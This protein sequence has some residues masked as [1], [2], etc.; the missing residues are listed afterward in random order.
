M[1]LLIDTS[2]RYASIGLSVEGVTISEHT[3]RSNRNHSVELVPSIQTLMNQV[4]VALGELKAIFIAKGPGAFS[5]LRVGISTA[6]TLAYSLKIPIVAINTLEIES[7]PYLNLGYRVNAIIKAGRTQVYIGRFGMQNTEVTPQYE[8]ISHEQLAYESDSALYCGEAIRE[9]SDFLKEIHGPN[10]LLPY[11]VPPTRQISVLARLAY[12]KS[13][14]A[15]S[16]DPV[17]L[18]PFYLRSSQITLAINNLSKK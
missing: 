4:G 17:T 12:R 7:K 18:E 15:I 5:A 8:S 1:E 11:L 10:V 6:K 16:D 13:Q 3:W 2:T 14:M 9:L